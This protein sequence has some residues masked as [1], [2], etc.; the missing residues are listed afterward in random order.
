MLH[1]CRGLRVH[2]SLTL[3]GWFQWHKHSQL[4][5]S[6]ILHCSLLLP[7]TP[8]SPLLTSLSY[9]KLEICRETDLPK[10][11]DCRTQRENTMGPGQLPPTGSPVQHPPS[12]LQLVIGGANFIPA[13]EKTMVSDPAARMFGK[14]LL[15]NRPQIQWG[16]EWRLYS[17][18]LSQ[19]TPGLHWWLHLSFLEK[20]HHH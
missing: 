10:G 18:F 14:H 6:N 13:A 7:E 17:N 1:K 8:W 5:F 12:T 19:N 15:W 16:L 9:T 3:L 20:S 11:E 4:G 2:W